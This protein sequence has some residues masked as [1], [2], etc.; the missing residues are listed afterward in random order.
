MSGWFIFIFIVII[1]L[2]YIVVLIRN[3][4]AKERASNERLDNQLAILNAG[5][6]E[7]AQENGTTHT[8]PFTPDI[9]KLWG[10]PPEKEK[11]IQKVVH[12]EQENKDWN[13]AIH[14]HEA[15][16]Q[17]LGTELFLSLENRVATLPGIE[18]CLHQDQ[19]VFLIGSDMYTPEILTE[20]F[21]REFMHAA[22]IAHL[23]Q[24]NQSGK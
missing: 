23:Q 10:Y 11:I 12:D 8:M 2:L 15:A 24:L 7:M 22:E 3:F 16:E 20:L 14:I 6:T 5:I 21:W 9:Q 18:N 17:Y 13:C 4:Q 1:V 19:E